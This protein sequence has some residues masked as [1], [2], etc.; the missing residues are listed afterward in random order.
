MTFN[1]NGT[2]SFTPERTYIPRPDLSFGDLNTDT[3]V[4]VNTGLLG[5]STLAA[6]HSSIAALGL[7]T[8]VKSLNAKPFLH[9]TVFDFLF[10]YDDD[11]IVL[12]S[13]VVPSLVPFNRLGFMDQVRLMFPILPSIIFISSR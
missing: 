1:D 6:E 8:L 12:A 4:T 13:N 7:A 3:I 11:L 5:T 10:G 9:L 2:M